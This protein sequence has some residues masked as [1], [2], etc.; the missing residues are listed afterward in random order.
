MKEC[1]IINSL[2]K[3]NMNKCEIC[4]ETKITKKPCKSI[5][6]E[7]EL[8]GL[9]HSDLS[10]LKHTMTRGGKRFYVIFVDDHSRFT[11]LYLLRTKDEALEMFIKYKREVENQKNKR[12]K[13]LRTDR[14]GEYVILLR[15]F[16]NKMT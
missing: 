5:T 16:V 15:N 4:A 11:K 10:D 12:I 14:G 7:T 3:A 13:R 1:G 2:S 9:V 6:R 8:L